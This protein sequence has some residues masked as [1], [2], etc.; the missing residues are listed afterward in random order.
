MVVCGMR[1]LFVLLLVVGLS[2]GLCGAA[3]AQEVTGSISGTVTDSKGGAVPN[4]KVTI[5]NSDQQVVVRALTTD[6]RG[7][8]VAPL[9]PVRHYSVSV[10]GAGFK[11]IKHSGFV[12]NVTDKLAVNLTLAVGAA[13]A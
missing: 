11:K 10:E 4:A 8:Y 2:S 6:Q 12:L 1:R 5:T 9:L 3:W 7:Q 13:T